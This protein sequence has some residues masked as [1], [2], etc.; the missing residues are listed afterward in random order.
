MS[1]L[2]LSGLTF[3]LIAAFSLPALAAGPR[4]K[5]RGDLYQ[6]CTQKK[7]GACLSLAE[8]VWQ[9]KSPESRKIGLEYLK[10]ACA[11]KSASACD[12]AKNTTVDSDWKMIH[13]AAEQR[14]T[15][16]VGKGAKAPK[17]KK[18]VKP[19]QAKRQ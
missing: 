6:L 14:I 12:L 18:S 19:P 2:S 1:T 16:S 15:A 5:T 13:G 17:K 3:L 10:Y 8:V 7:A 4:P 9:D 11:L